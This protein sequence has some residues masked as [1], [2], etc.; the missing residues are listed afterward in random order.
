MTVPAIF[1]IP[2]KRQ[3]GVNLIE[4][5]VALAIGSVL[6]LGLVQIFGAS[7]AAFSMA[8]AG[9]RTQ[10]NARFA[11]DFLR[12][13]LR[14]VGHMGCMNERGYIRTAPLTPK[15]YNHAANPSTNLPAAPFAL[16]LDMPVQGFE[17][18]GT[19]PNGALDL[20]A[21]IGLGGGAGAYSPGLPAALGDLATDAVRG[22]D[23]L[24][25]RYLSGESARSVIANIATNVLTVANPADI[26]FF[27]IRGVYGISNCAQVSLFQAQSAGAA[28]NA[29]TGGLNLVPFAAIEDGYAS[30]ATGVYRYEYIVY[31]VG[32]D[33]ASGEPSLR[34]RRLDPA[35]AQLLSAAQTLVEGVE[36]MQIVYGVDVDIGE[37]RDDV[38]DQYVTA[39]AVAGLDVNEQQ[40]WQR[41]L[42]ARVG[43][44]MRA[45]NPSGAIRDAASPPLRIADTTVT[46]ADDGRLRQTY[47]TVITM[48][49]RVRN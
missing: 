36:S 19:P 47:E 32:L 5:M 28:I 39:N 46:V 18:T 7:R 41:V 1:P 17:Y 21:G 25:V 48:R 8:E 29:G 37:F 38:L 27:E 43:L 49:N 2:H 14:M 11:V 12:R 44:L 22:S 6:L 4:L 35:R 24:V 13:D 9:A 16:R 42:N 20:S 10:E 26:P 3:A 30:P 34:Q 33:G 40:A 15:M 45:T 31:Y 23:V